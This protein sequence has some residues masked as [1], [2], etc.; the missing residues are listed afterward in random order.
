MKDFYS[1]LGVTK[2]VSTA[3][4]RLAYLKLVRAKHPDQFSDPEQRLNAGREFQQINE[5]FNQLRDKKTRQEYDRVLEKET[6]SPELE[7]QGY[8]EKG[9]LLEKTY[10]NEKA[11]KFYYEAMRLQ[12]D[13]IEY[14]LATGRLLSKDQSKQHQAADLFQSAIDKDPNHLDA[15]LEL[16][17]LF[18]RIGM[19][20]RA[21]RV[22]E[23]VLGLYPANRELKRRLSQ[24]KSK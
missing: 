4:M 7:A 20:V 12:P 10:Q 3:E 2:K 5:A 9:L 21:M 22:Y 16:G 19:Y 1:I 14:L 18:T 23:I 11:L 17:E 15:Y 6:S 24:L 8:F 13:N